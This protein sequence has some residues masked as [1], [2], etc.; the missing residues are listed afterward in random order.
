[1][2]QAEGFRDELGN[3]GVGNIVNR[4]A[5]HALFAQSGRQ[6]L[7]RRLGVSVHGSVGD[8]HALFFRHIAA[9]Q[10]V[11]ADEPADIAAPHGAVQRADHADVQVRGLFQQ[12]LHGSSVLAHDIGVIAAGVFQPVALEVHFIVEQLSV[13]RAEGAERVRGEQ[14]P[15]GLVKGHHGLR[16]VHHGRVDKGHHMMP[17][18]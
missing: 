13:Q 15:F 4:H 6:R 16:P 2:A 5:G 10:I 12:R 8:E 18:A 17:E 1:M 14:D 11:F 7:R 9:P 3:V